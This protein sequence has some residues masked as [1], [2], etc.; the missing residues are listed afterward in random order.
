LLGAAF[1]QR[2][3]F[4]ELVKAAE[5][6][7][8]DAINILRL[9]AQKALDDRISMNHVRGAARDWYQQD[10]SRA[11]SEHADLEGLLNWIIDDVI[12]GRRARAFLL[13][14]TSTDARIEELF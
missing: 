5:G 8:R 7:P 12:E 13:P 1:T 9:A 2:N 3:A 11:L 14:T 10:K 6:V 4:D